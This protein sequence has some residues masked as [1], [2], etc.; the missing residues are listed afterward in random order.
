MHLGALPDGWAN[1][2]EISN[3]THR[4]PA[5]RR[6]QPYGDWEF[7]IKDPNGYVLVFSELIP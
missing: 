6:R 5:T 2:P 3:N 4:Y 7:E 1:A